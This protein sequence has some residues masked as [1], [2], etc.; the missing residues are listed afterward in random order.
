MVT[1]VRPDRDP[2][3][4]VRFQ[5]TSYRAVM[6]TAAAGMPRDPSQL[7]RTQLRM[8]CTVTATL[9]QYHHG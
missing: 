7:N 8:P 9:W 2:S 6:Y 3:K 1:A 5:C 4:D